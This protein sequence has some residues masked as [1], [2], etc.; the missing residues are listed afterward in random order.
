[1]GE[2]AKTT[3]SARNLTQKKWQN[4]Q[5]VGERRAAPPHRDSAPDTLPLRGGG[6][7]KTKPPGPPPAKGG[8][9]P[10]G[11]AAFGA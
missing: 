9:N 3:P 5:K 1:M 10:L 11:Q 4:P 2:G 8:L 7:K 6:E